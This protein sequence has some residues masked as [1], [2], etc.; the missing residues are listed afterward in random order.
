MGKIKN[1][2]IVFFVGILI[3]LV[4]LEVSLRIVGV[5]Y[6]RLS[7]SDTISGTG[8][9]SSV[10]TTILSVGDSVTFGIGAPTE[11]SY[12]AQLQEM[13]NESQPKSKYTVINRGRPAQNS[14]Q[15]LTRLEE[16][17]QEF[18]PDIVT[19][20]IGAQNLVNYFGYSIYL[21]SAHNQKRGF[22]LRV[23]DSLD[24]IRVYKFFRLIFSG[25]KAKVSSDM[26]IVSGHHQNTSTI[27]GNPD[28]K[29]TVVGTNHDDKKT[30]PA[31]NTLPMDH[32]E[33]LGIEEFLIDQHQLALNL[34]LT[35]TGSQR[36][37]DISL[38]P[39]FGPQKQMTYA[40]RLRPEPTPEC[41]AASTYR[42]TGEYDKALD[43]LLTVIEKKDVESECYYITGSIYRDWKEYDKAI[44]FFKKGIELDPGQFRNYEGIGEVYQLQ[45]QLIRALLWYKKGFEHTR[46]DSLYERCYVGINEVFNHMN[47]YQDAIQFFEKET[48]RKPLV[49]D[50]IHSLANDYLS[51]F[52][53]SESK[54]HKGI[55]KTVLDWIEADIEQMIKLCSQYNAKVILQNYPAEHFSD[56][57][58]RRIAR[59]HHLP[60]VDHQSTFKNFIIND[61]QS[62]EYFVPDGHPNAKGYRLMAKKIWKAVKDNTN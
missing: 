45:N 59:R 3:F 18:S 5:I 41:V 25:E 50:Y 43:L 16:Q 22:L 2:L 35:D 39:G 14:A 21:E 6:A 42:E 33:R 31:G 13:L 56:N 27:E 7:E 57:L 36:D 53:N 48:K 20:L 34:S 23:H 4:V 38:S 52:K 17:L 30:P 58:F 24:S 47:N 44:E 8:K 10:E 62:P 55:D 29:K 11:L 12:P 28:R 54:R 26:D 49:N 60:F 46:Y 19:I 1:R 9:E 32:R 37:G 51:L 15:L 40:D 61:V